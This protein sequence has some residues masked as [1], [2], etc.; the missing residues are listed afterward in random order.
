MHFGVPDLYQGEF[1]GPVDADLF[2][3]FHG[4]VIEFLFNAEVMNESTL[5]RSFAAMMPRYERPF[6][7]P[8]AHAPIRPARLHE[9]EGAAEAVKLW[10]SA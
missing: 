2:V 4:P 7:L 1:D 3:A 9:V 5:W 10:P 8:H 6:F